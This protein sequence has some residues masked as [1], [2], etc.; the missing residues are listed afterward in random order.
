MSF[1]L[2]CLVTFFVLRGVLEVAGNPILH[3]SRTHDQALRHRLLFDRSIGRSVAECGAGAKTPGAACPGNACCSKWGF[4]GTASEFC[5]TECQSNCGPPKNTSGS[6]SGTVPQ[7]QQ[8]TSQAAAQPTPQWT[9]KP[10]TLP[11]TSAIAQPTP[12]NTGKVIA[13]Y[14]EGWNMGKPCGTMKP[15]EIPVESLTHLIFSFGFVAPNTYQIQPM[16]DTKEDL[17]TQATDVKKRNS[18]LKV[19]V[20]LGGWTHTGPGPYRE[21]FTTMVSLPASRQTFITNLI[22]FL[23]QHGFDGVD[24]DW[25]YPGPRREGAAE[26]VDWINVMAYDIHGTW[27]S[28]KKAAGHTNLKDVEKRVE[29]FLQAGIAP[30]KLV[31]GTAFYGR[32]LKMASAGC[33]QPGYAFTGP[34]PEGQ[35]VKTAGFLSY[36]E[37]KDIISSGAQPAFDPDGSVQ[38]LTWGGGN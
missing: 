11:S 25:E 35:C 1:F 10:G 3:G 30:N 7:G 26:A 33:T 9:T 22:S 19:L 34:G 21:V 16:P 29:T 5:G 6:Q 28:D 32:S 20:A 2:Q 27:E 8:Q 37:I 14:W 12:G 24:L 15:E 23:D 38:H 13:G 36:T 4:C 17:F 18:N 31:L